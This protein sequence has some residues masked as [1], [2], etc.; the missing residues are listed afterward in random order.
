M[1]R[2]APTLEVEGLKTWFFTRAG[3][4]KA[5]DEISFSV[6]QGKILGLVGEFWDPRSDAFS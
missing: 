3:I 2:G 5:V 6:D 4:V 1:T